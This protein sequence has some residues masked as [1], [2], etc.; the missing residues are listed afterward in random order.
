MYQAES[1][2]QTLSRPTSVGRAYGQVIRQTVS[3]R[4]M[5]YRV[6]VEVTQELEAVST[7]KSATGRRADAI[8]RNR[9]LWQTLAYAVTDDANAL[10]AQLRANIISLSMWVTRE[11]TRTLRDNAP[12]EDM[13]ETNKIIMRGL[14]PVSGQATCP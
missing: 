8:A 14:M 1:E 7:L 9:Q 13:I 4:E 10:P 2:S 3:P 5:E 12:L 6:F 11:C